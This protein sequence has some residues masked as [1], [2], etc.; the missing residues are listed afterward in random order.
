[1]ISVVSG[2]FSYTNRMR[3][4]CYLERA[5]GGVVCDVPRRKL[6]NDERNQFLGT[7]MNEVVLHR[8]SDGKPIQVEMAVDD[9]FLTSTV[10]DGLIVATATGSTGYSLSCGGSMVHPMTQSVMLTPICPISLSFRPIVLPSDVCISMRVPETC[11]VPGQVSLDGLAGKTTVF[12]GDKITV[13]KGEHPAPT[14]TSGGSIQD[15]VRDINVQLK[16]NQTPTPK[17]H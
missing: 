9:Q 14:I 10:G 5:S 17:P 15:W 8:G 11:R 12:V 1:M 16:W 6:L 2:G 7:A 13:V 4:N 3:L